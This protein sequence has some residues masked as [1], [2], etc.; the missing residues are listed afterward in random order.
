MKRVALMYRINNAKIIV[1]TTRVKKKATVK[2]IADWLE[3][4]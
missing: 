4:V 3:F 1:T 2:N